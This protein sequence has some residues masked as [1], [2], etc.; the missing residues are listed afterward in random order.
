MHKKISLF[1]PLIIMCLLLG[2][3]AR[4]LFFANPRQLPTTLIGKKIPVFQLP[5]ILQPGLSVTEK[6]V[7]GHV[8]LI[9]VWATW[10][11]ACRLEHRMLIKINE[12]Y[13]VP[14]I[15]II[16]KDNANEARSYLQKAGNPYAM[17]G[18]DNQ[19]EVAIDFGIYGTPETFIINS[20]GI[21]VYRHVGV[22]DQKTW[23]TILYPIVRKCRE[24]E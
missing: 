5:N 19:G 4:E 8:T 7:A 13:H 21:I 2:L 24:T 3:L 17:I 1:I 18:D 22:I 9:N 20:Q 12:Q 23:D 10:C 6:N 14:M 11:D 16:Y 15:G